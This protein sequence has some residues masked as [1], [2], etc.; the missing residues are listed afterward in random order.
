MSSIS[1]DHGEFGPNVIDA[2]GILYIRDS[3]EQSEGLEGRKTANGR[4]HYCWFLGG[5]GV[6]ERDSSLS[7]LI[8]ESNYFSR[9]KLTCSSGMRK[10]GG[11]VRHFCIVSLLPHHPNVK[12]LIDSS[13][14]FWKWKHIAFITWQVLQVNCKLFILLLTLLDYL[15]NFSSGK[16]VCLLMK[17]N[18]EAACRW[19]GKS[20]LL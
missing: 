10:A 3:I 7:H 16:N 1:C 4:M 12:K 2:I 8:T 17:V 14:I 13:I 9:V 11:M 6:M 15:L 19:H 18:A 5:C 20:G